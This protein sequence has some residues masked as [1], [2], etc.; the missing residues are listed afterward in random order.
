[1]IPQTEVRLQR[2]LDRLKNLSK[3]GSK[4]RVA[5][6]PNSKGPLAGEVG[7]DMIHVYESN[8]SRAMDTLRHEFI[9]YVIGSAIEPYREVTNELIKLLNKGAY[10]RKECVVEGL[11]GLLLDTIDKERV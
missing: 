4:L 11:K 5:W 1:M 8:E 3:L 9:D 10:K 2:E 7:D 6:E